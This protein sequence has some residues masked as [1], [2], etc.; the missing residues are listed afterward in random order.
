MPD[1]NPIND[2]DEILREAR[3]NSTSS[4]EPTPS[5]ASA[6]MASDPVG[7]PQDITRSLLN[8]SSIYP[9]IT[10]DTEPQIHDLHQPGI[11]E[12]VPDATD[13]QRVAQRVPLLQIYAIVSLL[14]ASFAVYGYARIFMQFRSIVD[15][16]PAMQILADRMFSMLLPSITLTA[17]NIA[18]AVYLL[19]AKSVKTVEVIIIILLIVSGLGILNTASTSVRLGSIMSVDSA[20]SLAIS[21]GVWILLFNVRS[22]VASLKY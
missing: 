1:I 2:P 10:K 6:G 17:I 16:V 12:N 11:R 20:V 8:T 22:R 21:I 5:A 7:A 9:D 4:S 19:V 3:Q 18:L 15:Q 14:S 13:T